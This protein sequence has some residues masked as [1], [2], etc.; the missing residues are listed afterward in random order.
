MHEVAQCIAWTEQR[1]DAKL[2]FGCLQYV[3]SP[4]K[5]RACHIS[6]TVLLAVFAVYLITYVTNGSNILHP[7]PTPAPRY[8]VTNPGWLTEI[9]YA[10]RVRWTRLKPHGVPPMQAL[11]AIGELRK[12]I[13]ISEWV[14]SKFNGTSTPKGSYLPKQVI[15]IPTSIQVATV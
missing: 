1:P 8:L 11:R 14:L 10:K 6:P 12:P 4:S 2:Y 3:L 13:G 7:P 15:T 5:S 9:V